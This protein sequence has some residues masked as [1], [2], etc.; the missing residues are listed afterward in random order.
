MTKNDGQKPPPQKF[1]ECKARKRNGGKCGMKFL[2]LKDL[3][4]HIRSVHPEQV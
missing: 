3:E 4:T 2:S 1:L